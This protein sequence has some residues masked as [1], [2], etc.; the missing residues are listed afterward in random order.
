MS[1]SPRAAGALAR[2]PKLGLALAALVSVGLSL[3]ALSPGHLCS[4]YATLLV[5]AKANPAV[6]STVFWV[7]GHAQPLMA[8]V[9]GLGTLAVLASARFAKDLSK[10]SLK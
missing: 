3:A 8:I 1:G 4:D 9:V 7:L 5:S 2:A 6:T 10:G